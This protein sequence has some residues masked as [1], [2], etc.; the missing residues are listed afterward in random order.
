MKKIFL[1]LSFSF[2][3]LISFSQKVIIRG[4]VVDM[5][6]SPLPGVKILT[7]DDKLLDT[8]G[9]KGFFKV[10]VDKLP[11]FLK[12]KYKDFEKVE[13]VYDTSFVKVVFPF[14]FGEPG[15]VY[16]K[17]EKAPLLSRT[18]ETSYYEESVDYDLD[19]FPDIIDD[20]PDDVSPA[21][22]QPKAGLLTAGEVNDFAKWELWNDIT[23]NQLNSYVSLWKIYPHKRFSVQVAD[24]NFLPVVNATVKLLDNQGNTIWVAKTDN[25]GKA[26]LWDQMFDWQKKDKKEKY[27]IAVYY[28]GEV[29]M[30]KK[31]KDFYSGINTL[32]IPTRTQ[33]PD[34][35]DVAFTI[36]ITGSMGDE[37]EY[38]KAEITDIIS[39]VKLAYPDLVYR[40][41]IVVYKDKS[42]E[43]V[44]KYSD[45]TTD[46]RKQIDFLNGYFAGGGGDYPEA[47]DS[48]VFVAVNKLHWSE[49]ARTRV[50]F[51]VLDAP[52]HQEDEVIY[53]L[54][55]S[56]YESAKKGIRIV[57]L[58]CSGID[59][60]TEYLMRSMALATNG[61]YTFLT[62]DSGIGGSHIKPT[63]DKYDVELLHDLM[64]RIL[65]KYI[66]VPALD[67]DQFLQDN[68]DIQDTMLVSVDTVVQN[69]TAQNPDSSGTADSTVA[70]IEFKDVLKFYPN[71]TTGLFTVKVLRPVEAFYVA[72]LTGKLLKRYEVN[73]LTEIQVN[74]SE[75]VDGVYFVQFFE[76]NRW[77]SGKIILL[78]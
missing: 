61:T 12:F 11:V 25:T 13:Y 49:N 1:L 59:K 69:S 34:T 5:G 14:H 70:S 7:A 4:R 8:A 46:Y 78:R 18:A 73:G 62:D 2:I 57:P 30:I 54:N 44:Y 16:K 42:D 26:E 52:P 43:F 72:D 38:L 15:K 29:Y 39:K 58:T 64:I 33:Y 10:K 55:K 6:G 24:T 17:R 50:M 67:K 36:D 51:L 63:T 65:K 27:K 41:A 45:F 3:V 56:V 19:F 47:V 48:A 75:F 37:L 53:T 68:T 71:P 35:V 23:Q 76:K 28:G 74:I 21:T 66:E 60:S 31:A 77:Y 9:K 22:I 40:V 32:T 20:V